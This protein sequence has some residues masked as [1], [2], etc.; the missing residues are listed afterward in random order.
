[1]YW[2]LKL[3]YAIIW[4]QHNSLYRKTLQNIF[5]MRWF[6]T[7]AFKHSVL[8]P[9]FHVYI[10]YFYHLFVKISN[11]RQPTLWQPALVSPTTC[12]LPNLTL[13]L[14]SV[15]NDENKQKHYPSACYDDVLY[16]LPGL[17]VEVESMV[18]SGQRVHGEPA[19]MS[20]L[21]ATCMELIW[22]QEEAKTL[23]GDNWK[24]W[25]N[26]GLRWIVGTPYPPLRTC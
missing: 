11:L 1:M 6:W 20:H 4:L 24:P 25:R 7:F 18:E 12:T 2:L 21:R 5:H 26:K 10:T 14:L 15:P 22:F 3:R 16:L 17:H 23:W 8:L 9:T 19:D 13:T